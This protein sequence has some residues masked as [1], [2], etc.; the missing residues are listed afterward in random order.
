MIDYSSLSKD[1]LIVRLDKAVIADN[2][3]ESEQ[4]GLIKEAASRL[5]DIAQDKLNHT[6]VFKDPGLAV[7]LQVCIKVLRDLLPNIVN[8]LKQEGRLAFNEA[9][10]RRL[11]GFTSP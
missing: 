9:R 5:A 6:N 10:D 2:F 8:G 4:W 3:E 1:E 11:D 7:E